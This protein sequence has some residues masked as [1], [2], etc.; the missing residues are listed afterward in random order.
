M[1]GRAD[2]MYEFPCVSGGNADDECRLL[3]SPA[4]HCVMAD[5]ATES[6]D[7]FS[8]KGRTVSSVYSHQSPEQQALASAQYNILSQR[9]RDAS[10]Q[11][12]YPITGDPSLTTGKSLVCSYCGKSLGTTA[13]LKTHIRDKHSDAGEVQ[14]TLCGRTYRNKHSLSNHMNLYHKQQR[15]KRY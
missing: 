12:K 6:F 14:C 10:C 5:T 3:V 11:L 4:E 9:T 2:G 8:F 13:G 15:Y 1:L 7:A